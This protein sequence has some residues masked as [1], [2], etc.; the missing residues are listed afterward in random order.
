M[1]KKRV[2]DTLDIIFLQ[3][4]SIWNFNNRNLLL[5][6]VLFYRWVTIL[7]ESQLWRYLISIDC[8]ININ[9]VIKKIRRLDLMHKHDALFKA[10]TDGLLLV[11][12]FSGCSRRREAT[13]NARKTNIEAPIQLSSSP[14]F[15]GEPTLRK[16]KSTAGY[17]ELIVRTT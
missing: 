7:Y 10:R 11:K 17:I 16:G 12:F 4:I 15:C 6:R 3:E 9:C 5:N 2:K 13:Q 1:I 14:A 8:E